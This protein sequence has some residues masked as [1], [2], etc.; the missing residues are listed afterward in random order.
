MISDMDSLYTASPEAKD[1]FDIVYNKNISCVFQPVISLRDGSVFGYEFL[2]RGP[3]NSIFHSPETLIQYSEKYNVQMD[4]E[5]LFRYIALKSAREI[6][7]KCK[8][9]LNINPNIIQDEKF[10]QGFTKECLKEF[11]IDPGRIVFEVTEREAV[12][13]IQLFKSIIE[14]YKSQNYQIS[15]DD[16]GAGY[17]GLNLISDV[18]PHFIKLDMQL[19][20]DIDKDLTKQALVKSMCEF[21]LLTNTSI[22]AEGVETKE[23][24]LKLIEFDVAYAQGYYIQRP[25]NRIS[26]ISK[27]IIDNI[28]YE[29]KIKNRFFGTKIYDF[30]IKNICQP[31]MIVD[32][33]FIVSQVGA[34]FEENK[35]LPGVCVINNNIPVGIITRKHFY[36]HLSGQFGYA[37][38]AEKSVKK[39]MLTDFLRIDYRTTIDVAA[40]KAMLRDEESLY[41]FIT[42]TKDGEY[43]GIVT[44]KEL[45]ERTIEI[46]VANAKNLNPLSEL[47][48]NPVIEAQLEKVINLKHERIVLYFD[49]DNFKAYND[50]Y[51]FECGDR[52]LKQLTRVLRE[53]IR[54]GYFLGHIGGDDFVAIVDTHSAQKLC[55]LVIQAFDA[56]SAGFYSEKDR[57]RG[58]VLVKNR[59]SVEEVFPLMTLS[60]VGVFSNTYHNI[61]D[62]AEAAGAL[63]K[64][65]KQLQGSNCLLE[66]SDPQATFYQ[67]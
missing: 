10:K 1:F 52:V 20:R 24:L 47:P 65:C 67:V 64:R 12:V 25:S 60:I 27:D 17:S 33:H 6:P 22:I 62:L 5:Y 56:F 11:L 57:E 4:L 48:G 38:F 31:S 35:N 66:H 54:P 9:F 34:V 50:L 41:D 30:Y 21:S 59:Q 28:H 45:L 3:A 29:N 42:V 13:N 15:I 14:H 58:Y 55:E 49:V 36:Q 39:I 37:L 7:E 26:D 46:E 40:K 63:K 61:Y 51:G 32:E 53:H 19:I 43:Y 2:S 23:E 16:A 18:Q 8:L 44:I